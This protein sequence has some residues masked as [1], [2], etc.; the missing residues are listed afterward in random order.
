M[1]GYTRLDSVVKR[2]GWCLYLFVFGG[3]CVYA[4][5]YTVLVLARQIRDVCADMI[6]ILPLTK[7]IETV[8]IVVVQCIRYCECNICADMKNPIGMCVQTVLSCLT[9]EFLVMLALY[10]HY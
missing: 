10:H 5:Y 1:L 9:Y 7:L 6:R 3:R 2:S 4:R 8:C